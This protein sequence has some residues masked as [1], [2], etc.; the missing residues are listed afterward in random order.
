MPAAPGRCAADTWWGPRKPASADIWSAASCAMGWGRQKKKKKKKKEKKK[1]KRKKGGKEQNIRIRV[2]APEKNAGSR[3]CVCGLQFQRVPRLPGEQFDPLL[4]ALRR[5]PARLGLLYVL[6]SLVEEYVAARPVALV[7]R[8]HLSRRQ[9]APPHPRVL[10]LD[11][12][13]SEGF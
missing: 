9:A 6:D 1:K 11:L 2:R 5:L 10:Q 7:L 4:N 3:R 12:P 8:H 13:D